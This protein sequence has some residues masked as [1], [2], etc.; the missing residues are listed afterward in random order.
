MAATVQIHE[1]S[2]TM[3]GTDK[4]SAT[5]RF[6]L[7]DDATYDAND[8]I[9][10]PSSGVTES[11]RKVIRMNCTGAP[12]TQIDNFKFYSDGANSFTQGITVNA[13]NYSASMGDGGVLPTNASLQLTGTVNYFD[14]TSGAFMDLD[15]I[16]TSVKTDTGYFGDIVA[17][18]MVI[19]TT[20]TSGTKA[21]ETPVT[22]AYDEI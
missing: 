14:L 1:M 9:T 7:A 22:F 6:K 2:A 20:A 4:T 11:F 19:D 15:A 17:L 13:S 21:A 18:Q 12:G 16:H 10:I 5:I 8:P 3:T